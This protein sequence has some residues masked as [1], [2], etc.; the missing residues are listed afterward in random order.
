MLY[1]RVVLDHTLPFAEL[2]R[3]AHV[4]ERAKALD[5]ASDFSER[6]RAPESQVTKTKL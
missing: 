4:N 6:I 2:K 3:R 5:D 1:E